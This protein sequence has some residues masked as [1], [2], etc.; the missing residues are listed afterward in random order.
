[1]MKL[2][3][4][5]LI[6][7]IAAV[8]GGV[9]MALWNWVMPGLYFDINA[10]DYWHAL[11]LLVLSRILVGGFRGHGRHGHQGWHERHHWHKWQSMT[12]EER[13]QF[14]QQRADMFT[15]HDRPTENKIA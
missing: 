10:I 8:L 9:V 15:R 13:D 2:S 12:Q 11:G 7:V 14:C 4:V 3:K 5:L 6:L 1:M